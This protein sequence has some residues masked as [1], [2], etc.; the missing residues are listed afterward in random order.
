MTNDIL[1]HI[2]T[3]CQFRGM[4]SEFASSKPQLLDDLEL[5]DV[6]TKAPFHE[7]HSLI[8]DL[9]IEQVWPACL[10]VTPGEI[11]LFGPLMKLRDAPK[12]IFGGAHV[13]PAPDLSFLEAFAQEGFVMLRSDS[14]PVGGRAVAIFGSAGRFWSITNNKPKAFASPAEFVDF[15]DKGWAKMA[16]RLEA[17]DLGDGRTRIET[18]TL[19]DGTDAPSTR[20]FAP[21]WAIIRGPSGLIRRSWLNAIERRARR[22][23]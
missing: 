23:Q 11:R 12:K 7:L 17:I 10:E 9:P 19:V 16:A 4:P 8:V 6:L 5:A 2:E 18:E 1:T 22:S 3:M 20:K 13:H 21:Y 15:E 14:S